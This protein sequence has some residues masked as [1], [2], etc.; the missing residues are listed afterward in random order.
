[1]P[2]RIRDEGGHETDAARAPGSAVARS[3][4]VR[5]LWSSLG[6]SALALGFV[7][8]FLPLLPTTPFVLL[9]AFA[10]AR[11]SPRFHRWLL[12][13][14]RFGPLIA[15]WQAGRGIELR[16][17]IAA[18][19]LIVASVGSSAFVFVTFG[20]ARLVLLAVGV[21]VIAFIVTRPT[22]PGRAADAGTAAP[23]GG[24]T[25]GER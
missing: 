19:V 2:S 3:P 14:P 9:A 17:K 16:A 7:G 6:F 24:S 18:I 5:W 13:H 4:V 22:A 23:R 15:D 10:F 25:P 11:S 8:A 20:W 1:M 21:G 12:R